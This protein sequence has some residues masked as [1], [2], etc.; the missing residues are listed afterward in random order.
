MS[1]DTP[2]MVFLVSL[3]RSGSTLLHKMLAVS[4]QVATVSEPWLMLPL[5]GMLQPQGTATVYW[6]TTG[7]KA[8]AELA[9]QLPGGR[10]EFVAL[11][12]DFARN[13][14]RRLPGAAEAALFLDK[15]PRYYL[16]APFLA[17]AFP[18]AR[19]VFLFRDPLAVLNSALRTWHKNRISPTLLGSYVD[20]FQGPG[21]MA[22]GL[23]QLG[24]RALSVHYDD[25][26]TEP[27]TALRRICSHIG[28]DYG[29]GMTGSYRDVRFAGRMGDPTGINQYASISTDSLDGGTKFISNRYRKRFAIRYL[30]SMGPQVHQAFGIDLDSALEEIRRIRAPLRGSLRDAYGMAHLRFMVSCNRAVIGS[31]R[32]R[33]KGAEPH[34]PYG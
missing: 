27:E 29:D 2:R 12:A 17:E 15:T 4:P 31:R 6:H 20:I 26:V 3:P 10:A 14:Y 5:A 13:V 32:V 33:S 23:G 21:D 24:A 1:P 19:F 9:G 8:I 28:I 22:R 34:V 30:Q 11:V 16:I 25:L 7:H 18:E